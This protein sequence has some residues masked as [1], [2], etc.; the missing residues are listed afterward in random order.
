MEDDI[1]LAGLKASAKKPDDFRLLD[2][3]YTADPY[4]LMFRRDDPQFKALVDE[5]LIGLMRS[6][7]FEKLY[8]KWFAS[9][10]PPREINLH[11]PMS[12]KLKVLVKEP[13]DKANS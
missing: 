3:S 4:A 2:R 12:D 6:G 11:F 10:I 9:A 13:N 5:T 7:E 8:A 1:L